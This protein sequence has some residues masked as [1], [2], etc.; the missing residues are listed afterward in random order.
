MGEGWE[1]IV[2]DLTPHR[3]T[4]KS[5]GWGEGWEKTWFLIDLQAN[6]GSWEGWE[7]IVK[8]LTPHRPTSKSGGGGRMGKDSKGPDSS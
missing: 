2:K 5:G 1:R 8:D 7:R 6:Q 3:P 4:S